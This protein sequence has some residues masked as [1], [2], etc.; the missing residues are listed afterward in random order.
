MSSDALI[1]NEFDIPNTHKQW[2]KLEDLPDWVFNQL[3]FVAEKGN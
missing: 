3:F 1:P 2:E